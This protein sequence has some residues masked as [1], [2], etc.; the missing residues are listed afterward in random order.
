MNIKEIVT[1]GTENISLGV[2]LIIEKNNNDD[3]CCYLL[4]PNI[5]HLIRKKEELTSYGIYGIPLVN[6]LNVLVG[7]IINNKV[8]LSGDNNFIIFEN[9][10]KLSV[11]CAREIS[12]KNNPNLLN[13]PYIFEYIF[14]TV[15]FKENKNL[16]EKILK[17]DIYYLYEQICEYYK[18]KQIYSKELIN[19]FIR[20]KYPSTIKCRKKGRGY[21][22]LVVKNID[23]IKT[24]LESRLYFNNFNTLL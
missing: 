3:L 7:H 15:A 9:G 12:T 16:T 22:Y 20:E 8:Y 11:R 21:Y 14:A 13:S 2:S 17:K 24:I 10:I 1:K 6:N 4:N 5:E 18:I 19:K 23:E